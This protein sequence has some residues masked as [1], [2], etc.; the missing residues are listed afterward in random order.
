MSVCV[1]VCV[2]VCVR[3]RERERV[4]FKTDACVCFLKKCAMTKESVCNQ[5]VQI[6]PHDPDTHRIL[7]EMVS[8]LTFL[9]SRERAEHVLFSPSVPSILR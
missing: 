6:A 4:S 1:C 8:L 9:K 3:E 7:A 2:C 5:A